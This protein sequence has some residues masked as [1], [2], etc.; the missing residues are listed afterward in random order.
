M[1]ATTR[2]WPEAPATA[3]L[4]GLAI[5]SRIM[6]Q[7]T[8]VAGDDLGGPGSTVRLQATAALEALVQALIAQVGGAHAGEGDGVDGDQTERDPLA[9]LL[10]T[11][12]VCKSRATG[13]R[14]RL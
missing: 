9:E 7:R 14:S 6:L 12:R 8:L 5:T 3:N 10:H 4:R 1:S 13:G 2:A 11:Q